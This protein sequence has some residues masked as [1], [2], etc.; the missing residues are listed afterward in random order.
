MEH[1]I[2][3]VSGSTTPE[4]LGAMLLGSLV[5]IVFGAIPGLT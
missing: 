2:T 1:L 3:A 5:G 4:A